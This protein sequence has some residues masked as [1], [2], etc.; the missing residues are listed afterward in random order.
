M[1]P[2]PKLPLS[3]LA[4]ALALCVGLASPAS[5]Q[6]YPRLALH[7]RLYGNGF[8]FIGGGTRQG[9]ILDDVVRAAARYHELTIGASPISEY[10]PDLAIA[11]RQARPD[12]HLYAYVIGQDVWEGATDPDSLVDYISRYRRLVRD[13]DGF[14]YNRQGA[15][16]ST[17]NVN[18]AKRG[19]AGRF[20]V[21]EGIV[22]L[23]RDLVLQSGLWDG[24]FID[25]Y[26]NSLGWSQTPS[27]SIDFV[28]AGYPTFAAFDAAWLAATDTMASQLRR[29]AG[30]DFTLVGNCGQGTKYTT[31]NGWMRENF[32]FQNG[33]TWFENMFRTPGGYL[34]DETR[35]RAPRH[36]YN[37]SATSSSSTPYSAANTR[38]LRFGLGSTALGSGLHILGPGDLDALNYPYHWWWF[39]EYA[40]NLGTGLADSSQAHTGWLGQPLADAYQ[41]VWVGTN[42]ELV[43]N[44]DFE[45]DLSSWSLSSVAVPASVTRDAST[46][47]TGLS[48]AH[49]TA[50]VRGSVSYSVIF[51]ATPQNFVTQGQL[52]SA[53]FWAKASRPDTISV[54]ASAQ[55]TGLVALRDVAVTSEWRQYQVAL[56]PSM[57]SQT[58]LQ[59]YLGFLEGELWIDDVHFQAGASSMWRR[60]FQNGTVLVNPATGPMTVPLGRQ[61]RKIFGLHDPLTNDG[62]FVTQV[63]VPPSDALFL[64]GSDTTPPAA[65][66]DMRPVNDP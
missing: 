58:H 5:A 2:F 14:L 38:K 4:V 1:R 40:V 61:F 29:F 18:L 20:V 24:I 56:V 36:G 26:C 64:I 59:F 52:Y 19:L 12:I 8:P 49:I 53:T 65:I 9:P 32:P 15:H 60:D 34:T 48:S 28:R 25:Q 17:A 51:T 6:D 11:F 43:A 27:E 47:A 57:S 50:P 31:F 10:R 63:T 55:P 23:W 45:S 22:A 30:P 44:H 54:V 37:F 66:S 7:A 39:D 21:A 42:P 41:M 13:N 16:Y 3:R 35:F 33:G 46:A 62:S